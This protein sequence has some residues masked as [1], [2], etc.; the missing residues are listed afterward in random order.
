MYQCQGS[1][2]YLYVNVERNRI[3]MIFYFSGTGNSEWV[4]RKL[5]EHLQ[6]SV[7]K[8]TDLLNG[9]PDFPQSADGMLG[10]VFPVYS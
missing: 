2:P 1:S 8:L 4:A 6:D 10:F 3:R 7:Y 5:G 9:K